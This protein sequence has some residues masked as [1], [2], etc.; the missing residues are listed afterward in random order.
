VAACR[1]A[2]KARSAPATGL[3]TLAVSTGREHGA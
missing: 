3:A 1:P 2:A